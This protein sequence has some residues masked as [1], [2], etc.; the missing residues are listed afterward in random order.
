ME[1]KILWIIKKNEMIHTITSYLCIPYD[2]TDLIIF[3]KFTSQS[4]GF[5][6]LKTNRKPQGLIQNPSTGVN[7]G[8]FIST[9]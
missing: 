9:F 8:T 1:T 6:P 5:S 3:K 7:F 4:A 2:S